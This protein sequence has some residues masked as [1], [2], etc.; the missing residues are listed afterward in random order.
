MKGGKLTSK[1]VSV[2]KKSREMTESVLANSL[3]EIAVT[4]PKKPEQ[5]AAKPPNKEKSKSGFKIN[6]IEKNGVVA[7]I[8]SLQTPKVE[9]LTT[10][11]HTRVTP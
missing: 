3:D 6:M 7:L 1:Q 5:I 8:A 9:Y 11:R 4:A 2:P 10:E